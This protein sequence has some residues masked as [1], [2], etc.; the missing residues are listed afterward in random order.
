MSVTISPA[1][2]AELT[3]VLAALYGAPEDVVAWMASGPGAWLAR[4]EAGEVLGA[5]GL[6]PSP[7]HGA[8][9]MGGARPGLRQAEVATALAR[10]A[11]EAAGRVYAFAETHLF[12]LTALKAAG[13]REVG[14]Y[15]VLVGPTPTASVP[16]PEGV[17]LLPIVDGL[18]LSTH[19]A[20]I[21]T[22]EDRIGHHAATPEHT[23]P[24]VGGFDPELSLIAVDTEGR[25]AGI[26]SASTR[27]GHAHI[28]APGVRPD[29]RQTNL[30]AALLLGV[31]ALVRA[32][33]LGEVWIESWGDTPEEVS[34]DLSLG[35]G[36][37]VEEPILAAG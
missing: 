8:E 27:E 23:A 26:C 2:P 4:D 7:A 10:V 29:L 25:A 37:E 5:V 32:R 11:R 33:G 30:R 9:L 20:A 36:V 17:R 19:V 28:G 21:A 31:C 15:R 22:Y 6:R 12:P 14:A 18:N 24:E 34:Q 13:Y 16:L 1:Q 35:L 3:P